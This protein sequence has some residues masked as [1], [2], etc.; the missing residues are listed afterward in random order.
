MTDARGIKYSADWD[1]MNRVEISSATFGAGLLSKIKGTSKLAMGFFSAK[2]QLKK[3]SPL[4]VIGFG[5]YPSL[6]PMVAAQKLGIPTIIHEQNAILGKANAFLAPKADRIATGLPGITGLQ[7][8]DAI[9]CV[10]TGNPVRGDIAGLFTQPYPALTP[11]D[12]FKL[13][14]LGGSQGASVFADILPAALE[15]LPEDY[16]KRISIV[17][18]CRTKDEVQSTTTKYEALGINYELDTFIENVGEQLGS[19]HLV[20]ARS[21]ASTVAEVATAGRPAIFVPYPHH[22]DQQQKINAESIANNGGAWLMEEKDFT[23]DA[24]AEKLQQLMNE[25]QT[26]FRTAEAARSCAKPDAARK[27][28][29]LVTAIAYG[30]NKEE[31][32]P[33]DY[34]QGHL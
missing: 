1:D 26:L 21:G 18:Q 20:I 6:P 22:A 33:Y 9:R 13:F 11:D 25:P 16:I 32:K 19:S 3:I 34:T 29:N 23:A 7:E 5:G 4:V 27:L 30:W 31:Q 12:N 8:A 2:R 10:L 14:V 17:Q 15:K 28:G 24:L